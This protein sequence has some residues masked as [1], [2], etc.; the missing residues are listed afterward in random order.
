MPHRIGKISWT[1]VFLI[2][3]AGAKR[4]LR[5]V[6]LA[7]AAMDFELIVAVLLHDIAANSRIWHASLPC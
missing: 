5:A 4:N 2:V 6:G 7:A 1:D 3:G